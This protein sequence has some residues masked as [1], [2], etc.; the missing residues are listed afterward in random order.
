MSPNEPEPIFRPSLYLF[1]TRNSIFDKWVVVLRSGSPV[2]KHT[3]LLAWI[4]QPKSFVCKCNV[5]SNASLHMCCSQNACLSQWS[6]YRNE[7][8]D[9]VL[10]RMLFNDVLKSWT[11]AKH[12]NAF[13]VRVSCVFWLFSLRVCCCCCGCFNPIFNER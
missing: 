1:P 9:T 5:Q 7:I 3:P 13:D 11:L 2:V 10:L 4:W 12:K 8:H 6:K